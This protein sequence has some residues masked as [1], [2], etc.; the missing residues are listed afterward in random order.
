LHFIRDETP[1]GIKSAI[2]NVFENDE[3]YLNDMCVRG[4]QYIRNN[5][6]WNLIAHDIHSFIINIGTDRLKK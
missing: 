1:K 2:I 5:N 6:S 4:I 3:N